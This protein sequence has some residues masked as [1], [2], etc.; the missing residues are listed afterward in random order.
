[1]RPS[2]RVQ[3][4]LGVTGTAA[5]D[6][7]AACTG[8]VHVLSV[9]DSLVATA[10]A[11]TVLVIGAEVLTRMVDFTD[12][13]TCVLFGDGA[14]AAIVRPAEKGGGFRSWCL[15]SDGVGYVKITTGP[16]IERGRY[17]PL[18]RLPSSQ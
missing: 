7:L 15:S 9:A 1:M 17:T 11:E 16:D 12:R 6:L 2:C 18:R 3:E 14:G 8:F 5:F 4:K 13:N 10:L